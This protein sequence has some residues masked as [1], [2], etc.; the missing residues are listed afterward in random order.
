MGG[1][2]GWAARGWLA[3]WAPPPYPMNPTAARFE[4]NS[5]AIYFTGGRRRRG[6]KMDTRKRTEKNRNKDV[7]LY[8]LAKVPYFLQATSEGS[9]MRMKGRGQTPL[10]WCSS[11]S[12]VSK[13][14]SPTEN[15]Y[16]S[17]T[18]DDA[19]YASEPLGLRR[20]C[21]GSEPTGS[22]C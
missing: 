19:S 8:K 9:K 17:P 20:F 12:K 1:Q 5:R 16:A 13:A 6:P 3:L 22:P 15:M 11:P 14:S 4:L 7:I 18:R 10:L 2:I 21:P